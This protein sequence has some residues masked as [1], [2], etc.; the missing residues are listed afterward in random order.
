V[1]QHFSE[2]MAG[3][4]IIRCFQKERQFI[5]YIGYL[6]DNLSR[7][8]LYNAAAMEWLCFR[9]DML[10]SFVFSFTLILLVSSPSALIDP[11]KHII[12][13]AR[14]ILFFLVF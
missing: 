1:L 10:S 8:S 14:S 4:N 13:L 2:S 6:V 11:S 12:S 9:L 5:R 7:P 3:S